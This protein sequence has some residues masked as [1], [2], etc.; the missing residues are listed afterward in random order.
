MS[1]L[2][3]AMATW[4]PRLGRAVGLTVSLYLLA[5]VGWCCA[6][7]AIARGRGAEQLMM[8]SPFF[9]PGAVTDSVSRLSNN[10]TWAA[11]VIWTLVYALIAL[12]LLAATLATFN[13]CLGRVSNRVFLLP[14]GAAGPSPD[15][16]GTVSGRGL[17]QDES[18]FS[19]LIDTARPRED[20]HG[21][22][23]REPGRANHGCGECSDTTLS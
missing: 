20:N 15:S 1:S 2:G 12:M 14:H 21:C 9:W 19:S 16:P 8:G 6:I 4:C 18:G 3:L 10:G 23:M 13:R 7:A 17:F 22:P 11:A 5:A